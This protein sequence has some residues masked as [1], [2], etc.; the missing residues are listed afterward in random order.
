MFDTL[1]G[2]AMT[3]A[4]DVAHRD[5]LNPLRKLNYNAVVTGLTVIVALTIGTLQLA[6]VAHDELHTGSDLTGWLAGLNTSLVGVG[7]VAAFALITAVA[8]L[9]RRPVTRRT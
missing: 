1:D 2:A 4:Y 6:T 3:L 9:L 8:L 5:D 7:T